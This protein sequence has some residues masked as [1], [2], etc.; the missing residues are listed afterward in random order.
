[1]IRVASAIVSRVELIRAGPQEP[2]DQRG[3]QHSTLCGTS[4]LTI[5][6]QSIATTTAGPSHTHTHTHTH[7]H[8]CAALEKSQRER[9]RERERWRSS[10]DVDRSA[11][12]GRRRRRFSPRKQQ[13]V[14]DDRTTAT[15]TDAPDAADAQPTASAE[16]MEPSAFQPPDP[17]PLLFQAPRRPW[18]VGEPSIDQ[19]R[20]RFNNRFAI[21][22]SR[23]RFLIKGHRS[24]V[25]FF[26]LL[27][28]SLI[29][30][31]VTLS[32]SQ[33]KKIVNVFGFHFHRHKTRSS[34]SVGQRT[35]FQPPIGF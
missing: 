13:I 20:I 25:I 19:R 18:S 26:F 30:C 22:S 8:A 27:E 21:P 11:A 10:F 5:T 12:S 33:K 7:T 14:V 24:S 1:M 31:S 17:T 2:L 23:T 16:S 28:I 35:P 32:F 9:E 4:T 6:G 15:R 3:G 34:H 29:F